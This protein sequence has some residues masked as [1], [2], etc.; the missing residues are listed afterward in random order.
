MSA[1][2][3]VEIERKWL[4]RQVPQDEI[5]DYRQVPCVYIDQAYLLTGKR[6]L[7]LRRYGNAFYLTEKVG[8]GLSRQESEIAITRE[9]YE[10]L[11]PQ[12]SNLIRKYRFKI[13]LEGGLTLE[14]DQYRDTLAGLV[15]AECEFTTP[16]SA[17]LFTPPAWLPVIKEVTGDIDYSNQFLSKYGLPT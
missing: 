10:V 6:E 7:R 5:R 16:E 1:T 4:L 9:H 2:T 3:K 11:L 12:A 8:S 13:K 15:V 17:A 14:I